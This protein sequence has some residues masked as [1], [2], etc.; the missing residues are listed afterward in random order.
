MERQDSERQSCVTTLNHPYNYIE[1]VVSENSTVF[2]RG[3]NSESEG[4]ENFGY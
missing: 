4:L 1:E 2:S 3:T